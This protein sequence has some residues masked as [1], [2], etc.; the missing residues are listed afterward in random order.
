MPHILVSHQLQHALPLVRAG[1]TNSLPCALSQQKEEPRVLGPQKIEGFSVG[2]KLNT[3]I[4]TPCPKHVSGWTSLCE[5]RFH[6]AE[7]GR[8][9]VWSG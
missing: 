8:G 4:K 5:L 7:S 2:Y 6:K 1:V 9:R 3:F